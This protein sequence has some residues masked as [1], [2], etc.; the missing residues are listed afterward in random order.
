MIEMNYFLQQ[1]KN[2][3][4]KM[5]S[6]KVLHSTLAEQNK[7]HTASLNELVQAKNAVA[8]QLKN[9]KKKME[10]EEELAQ[11]NLNRTE[12]ENLGNFRMYDQAYPFHGDNLHATLGEEER[13]K[14]VPAKPEILTSRKF[15]P[16]KASLTKRNPYQQ[17]KS[18]FT[19]EPSDNQS[20]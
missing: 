16:T 19:I 20:R 11:K 8:G 15:H 2:R 13:P 17:T 4:S 3:L 6:G 1:S 12:S 10:D 9:L 14:K 18:S 5:R 7:R